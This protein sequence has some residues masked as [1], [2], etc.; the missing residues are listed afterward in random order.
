MVGPLNQNCILSLV[1]KVWNEGAEPSRFD[2]FRITF[3]AS[4][5]CLAPKF[6]A[7]S[8]ADIPDCMWDPP[9]FGKWLLQEPISMDHLVLTKWIFITSIVLLMSGVYS[10][11]ASFVAGVCCFVLLGSQ[12]AAYFYDTSGNATLLTFF[13]LSASPAL[14][15]HFN[16][17]NRIKN[18]F[19]REP[20]KSQIYFDESDSIWPQRLVHFLFF[21]IFFAAGL[22]KLLA[23]NNWPEPENL[24]AM[25]EWSRINYGTG[26][27]DPFRDHLHHFLINSPLA[28]GLLGHLTIVIELIS[29]IFFFWHRLRPIGVLMVLGLHLGIIS[30]MY[31]KYALIVPLYMIF[32]PWEKLFQSRLLSSLFFKYL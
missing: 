32:I 1:R 10:R 27:P 17:A 18:R 20:S 16:L 26:G 11:L 30:T 14:G 7:S 29:I 15:Q 31:F 12:H 23:F 9:G 8:A 19:K 4:C 2:L 24:K 3:G 28:L 25:L 21:F 13:V 5:L 6:F 22:S